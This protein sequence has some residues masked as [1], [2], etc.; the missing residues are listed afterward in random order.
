M[1]QE[2]L[3]RDAVD[4]LRARGSRFA[5]EAYV[6]VV[7]ALG[8][9]VRQLPPERLR[10]PARRH[11]SGQELT[12]GVIRIAR[13]EFGGLAPAVFREWGVLRTED[14]GAIVFELVDAGHLS[15]RPED[16]PEDFVTGID[17]PAALAAA[18][19]IA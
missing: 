3:F 18:T 9:T 5:R 10:D 2:I 1:S 11:L 15:A 7:A 19:G 14:I 8:E 17:L 16:R 12:A 6:F 4:E 13:E